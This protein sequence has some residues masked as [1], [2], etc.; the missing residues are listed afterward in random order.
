MAQYPLFGN[1][2][3]LSASAARSS[4]T[5]KNRKMAEDLK[6]STIALISAIEQEASTMDEAFQYLYYAFYDP[7]HDFAEGINY[8]YVRTSFRS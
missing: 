7:D 3:A 5:N 6:A 1:S 4:T 2:N 8:L